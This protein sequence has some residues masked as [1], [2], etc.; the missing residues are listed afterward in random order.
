MTPKKQMYQNQAE[1][2]IKNLEKRN[3]TGYYYESAG[4]AV[5][6]ILEKIPNFS[7]VTWGGSQTLSQ[8]GLLQQLSE[9]SLT[10]LNRDLAKT[11]EET[12]QIYRDSFSA[13]YYLMSTNA[14]TL[15]GKLVNIDGNSNRVAALAYGPDFVFI[16]AGM[17]K[18]AVDEENA[19]IRAKNFAAP[20]NTVRLNCKTPCTK[21]GSCN[22]CL[23]DDCI[24]CNTVITRKS[25]HNNRIH[26]FLIG[27]ELGF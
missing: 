8:I 20:A 14:I 27:E 21:T 2:I 1:T 4:A 3:M 24:C 16:V 19:L 13:D 22:D 23:V 5:E 9:K 10:L 25:R 12:K 17:N 7:V 11:P 26:V 15:D 18:V 6:A